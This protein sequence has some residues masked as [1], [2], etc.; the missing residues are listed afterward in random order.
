MR[1][2]SIVVLIA[3]AAA[4]ASGCGDGDSTPKAPPRSSV[5]GFL[6]ELAAGRFAAA[7]A[8]VDPSLLPDIRTSALADLKLPA[9][10]RAARR[11]AIERAGRTTNGC[12]RILR[13]RASQLGA[14]RIA[15]LRAAAASTDITQ[16]GNTGVWLF[17]PDQTWAVRPR[18]G[19]WS[20]I[21]ADPL[22]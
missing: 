9:H 17:A 2:A 1:H 12:P 6:G 18:N 10:D 20:I 13:L 16:A 8:R 5:T 21:I 15:A 11:A 19:S 14:E 3:V 22:M 4:V 7:C